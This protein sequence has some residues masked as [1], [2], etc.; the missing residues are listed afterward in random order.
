M[1]HTPVNFETPELNVEYLEG[2]ENYEVSERSIIINISEHH[3]EVVAEGLVSRIAPWSSTVVRSVTLRSLQRAIVVRSLHR[4]N[5]GAIALNKS[6]RPY[7]EY[8]ER[9]PLYVSPEAN[10]GR[11][12]MR[13]PDLADLPSAYQQGVYKLKLRVWFTPSYTDCKIHTGHDFL[14]IHTQLFGFGY[15]QKFKEQNEQS[16]YEEIGMPVGFT[17]SPFFTAQN[18]QVVYPWHRYYAKTD[19]VWLAIEF[20]PI[21][22]QN[23]G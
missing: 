4:E 6:W 11:V 5:I 7:F 22:P 14:E 8:P 10:L 15:M 20:W 1:M 23:E 17:H 19:C 12:E 16:L 2:V 18:E 9:T 13:I 21:S 3:A